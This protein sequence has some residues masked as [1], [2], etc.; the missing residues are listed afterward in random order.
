MELLKSRKSSKYKIRT[1]G[2][3]VSRFMSTTPTMFEATISN[4]TFLLIFKHCVQK[5]TL[6]SIKYDLQLNNHNCYST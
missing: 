5:S 6:R 3:R 1:I 4:E 2:I